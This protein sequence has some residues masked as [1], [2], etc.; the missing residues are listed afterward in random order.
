[1]LINFSNHPSKYWGEKQIEVSLKLYDSIIDFPF[2]QV[3]P[4]IDSVNISLLAEEI[5]NQLFIMF[6]KY[7]REKV[8]RALNNIINK[9]FLIFL[10]IFNTFLALYL[11]LLDQ[12]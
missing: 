4:N 6:S 2:P 7:N 9:M 11:L 8:E 3:D 10:I 1:M 5:A 12:S